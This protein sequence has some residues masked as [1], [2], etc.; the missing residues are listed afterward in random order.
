M[1]LHLEVVT[2]KG[3]VVDVET[4]E[5]ILPGKEGEFGVLEGHIPFLSA[6]KPG[7]LRYL[8]DGR[9]KQIAIGNGFAEVGVN[10]KVLVLTDLHALPDKIDMSATQQELKELEAKIASW[11]SEISPEYQALHDELAWA[12][13]RINSKNTN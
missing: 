8:K 13:A 5:V 3:A 12:Q 7:V 11:S 10:N 6:L 4:D 2:P 9:S 1:A